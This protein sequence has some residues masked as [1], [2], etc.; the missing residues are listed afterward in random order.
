MMMEKNKRKRNIGADD[1]G[2]AQIAEKNP[3]NQ[4]HQQTAENQIVQ[5]RMGRDIDQRVRS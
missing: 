1:D 5:H 2:A 3:L 4:E